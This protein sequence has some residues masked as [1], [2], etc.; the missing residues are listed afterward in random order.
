MMK[1]MILVVLSL[2]LLLCFFSCEDKDRNEDDEKSEKSPEEVAEL[3]FDAL[4]AVNI[5]QATKYNVIRSEYAEV[6]QMFVEMI[7]YLCEEAPYCLEEAKH[8]FG[9]DDC[10]EVADG[11]WEIYRE[12]QSGIG[13]PKA[14]VVN[15]YD[16]DDTAELVNGFNDEIEEMMEDDDL[17][18]GSSRSVVS[19]FWWIR[20]QCS[21]LVK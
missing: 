20:V 16:E 12:E 2:C 3:Y 14:T 15:Y 1:K 13:K 10:S 21:Q 17:D 4:T 11:I 5:E 18:I 7:E 9:T 6:R 8:R 19:T